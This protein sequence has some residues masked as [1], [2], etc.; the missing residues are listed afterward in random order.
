LLGKAKKAVFKDEK[1]AKNALFE[2]KKII[3]AII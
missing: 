3:K 2:R 1:R